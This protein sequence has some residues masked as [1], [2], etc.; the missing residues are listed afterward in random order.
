MRTTDLRRC[1]SFRGADLLWL[2]GGGND[3]TAYSICQCTSNPNEGWD[4]EGPDWPVTGP[5]PGWRNGLF[6]LPVDV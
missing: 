6:D 5:S 2:T 3:L 1:S 4:S